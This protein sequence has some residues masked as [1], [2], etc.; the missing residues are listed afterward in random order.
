[1]NALFRR[2]RWQLAG[3]TVL[4][5]CSILVIVGVA[6]YVILSQ[7]LLTEVDQ[8][9]SSQAEQVEES[10]IATGGA[11]IH[12]DRDG[13]GGNFFYLLLDDQG[14]LIANP[15]NIDLGRLNFHLNDSNPVGY[16]SAIVNGTTIRWFTRFVGPRPVGSTILLVGQSLAPEEE[17]LRQMIVVL[18]LV[19][20]GGLLL[21]IVGAW[22]LA[23]RALIPIGF[24]YRRQQEFVGDASHELRTPLTV[25]RSAHDLLD[26]HRAE[27][28]SANG[29]L[30]D[31]IRGEISRMERLTDD[32]LTLARSDQGSLYLEVGD[33]DLS[34]LASDVVALTTPLAQ[35]RQVRLDFLGHEQNTVV[36]GDPDR[37]QQLLLILVDNALKHTP[38]GGHVTVSARGHG[39]EVEIDVADT[40][41][42]IA[43][44]H[45]PRLFDRFYRVDSARGRLH[46]GTGLGLAIARSLVEAHGG[47]LT[48]ASVVGSGTTITVH[49]PANRRPSS[50]VSR[51][52]RLAA[53]VT[54]TRL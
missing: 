34:A 18:L 31:D 23:G 21:S 6:A 16:G 22:F 17:A 14:R 8:S 9:L 28:L 10:V 7:I 1:M 11:S 51:F 12:L 30:L 50:L 41:E 25:L 43:P 45:L 38:P 54:A 27:P 42:G 39:R 37:L 13:F 52:Q 36:E 29:A 46:G 53:R 4:V 20:G 2:I 49:I 47:H 24:A 15:Q 44:E 48:V 33:V 3:W 32:L 35:E 5:V 19:G 40:G 26:R